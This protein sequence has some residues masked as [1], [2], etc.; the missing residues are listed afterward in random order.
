MGGTAAVPVGTCMVWLWE[1]ARP[2]E[3]PVRSAGRDGKVSGKGGMRM[4]SANAGC[5]RLRGILC[6]YA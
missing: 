5:A 1:G 2:I 3:H 6:A 4:V